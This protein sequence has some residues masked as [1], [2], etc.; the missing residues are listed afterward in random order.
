MRMESRGLRWRNP[1][2]ELAGDA[3]MSWDYNYA[4]K[5]VKKLEKYEMAWVEEPFMPEEF[6]VVSE[7][8]ENLHQPGKY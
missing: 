5:M 2:G 3:W 6:E 8:K 4:L 1:H 7:Y